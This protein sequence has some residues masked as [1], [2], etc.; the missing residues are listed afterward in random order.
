M[1]WRLLNDQGSDIY[2]N[3]A[4]DEALAKTY[5]YSENTLNTLRFWESD[6]AVVIGRFQCVHKEVNLNYCKEN[7]IAIARRFTGGGAV[8][9][10][11]GNLNYSMRLHQIHDYDQSH[12]DLWK[13]NYEPRY[14]E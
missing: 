12:N 3:L 5:M 10:G 9:H 6:K 8:F 13:H 2:Q 11:P 7:E 4:V 14:L 1:S